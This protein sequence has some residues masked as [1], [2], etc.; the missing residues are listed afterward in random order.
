MVWSSGVVDTGIRV[1]DNAE[2]FSW[3]LW[4][5][6][7]DLGATP[8]WSLLYTPRSIRGHWS[9]YHAILLLALVL[10]LERDVSRK[11][12]GMVL[13]NTRD[14]RDSAR[15]EACL[16]TRLAGRGAGAAL[17]FAD[18]DER[19]TRIRRQACILLPTTT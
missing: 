13:L 17:G 1:V 3:V 15:R 2:E 19:Q 5:W 7:P 14:G 18:G 12:H 4:K 6:A 9:L 10:L 11:C 8:W 16:L